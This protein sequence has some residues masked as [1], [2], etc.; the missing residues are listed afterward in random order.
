MHVLMR[1]LIYGRV[2]LS[3][4]GR[5]RW[6]LPAVG[7]M[8]MQ[9]C[10]HVRSIEMSLAG[11]PCTVRTY[12]R[13]RGPATR[14]DRSIADTHGS[15]HPAPSP[16]SGRS[17]GSS[18]SSQAAPWGRAVAEPRNTAAAG[19]VLVLDSGIPSMEIGIGPNRSIVRRLFHACMR[20]ASLF[21]YV[22][23][24]LKPDEIMS[25]PLSPPTACTL[26]VGTQVRKFY[27]KPA[28]RLKFI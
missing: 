4:R 2:V 8:H 7:D 23:A 14:S 15:V 5:W 22:S 11:R 24:G 18:S 17:T 9:L 19:Q 3:A 27:S 16:V 1:P 26:Y 12:V 20:L 28:T 13:R 6:L 10:I 25:R 21:S